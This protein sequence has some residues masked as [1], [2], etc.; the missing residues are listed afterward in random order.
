MIGMKNFSTKNKTFENGNFKIANWEIAISNANKVLM[1]KPYYN[2]YSRRSFTVAMI[3][4]FKNKNF[5][6]AD[7]LTK[8]SYQSVSLQDCT[9][10][11]QYTILIEEI[12]NYRRSKKV[13]L[14]LGFSA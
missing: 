7:F 13:N 3:N 10:V 11:S 6:H 5:N 1:V 12:Y 8:L 2:G 9:S 4:C 14:R